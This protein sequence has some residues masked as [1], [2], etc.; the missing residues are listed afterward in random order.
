MIT[1]GCPTALGSPGRAEYDAVGALAKALSSSEKISTKKLQREWMRT[2]SIYS[3]IRLTF[4]SDRLPAL[5]GI[6]QIVTSL[7]GDVLRGEY[8]AGMWKCTLVFHLLWSRGAPGLGGSWAASASCRER[9]SFLVMGVVRR[10]GM[11]GSGNMAG[12]MD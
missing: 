10:R 1:A 7:S 6:A 12:R 4:E 5:A 2:V 3:R 8:L 9:M 11:V